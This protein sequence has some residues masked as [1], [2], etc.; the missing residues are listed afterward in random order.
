M[1]YS[2]IIPQNHTLVYSYHTPPSAVKGTVMCKHSACTVQLVQVD[3][4][5]EYNLI[6]ILWILFQR[7]TDTQH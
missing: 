6:K 1:L 3:S 5:E 7:D 2:G 4:A